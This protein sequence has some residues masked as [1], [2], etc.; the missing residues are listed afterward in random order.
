MFYFL[1]K[2]LE[3]EDKNSSEIHAFFYKAMA[4]Y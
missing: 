2:R 3:G 4:S 1:D